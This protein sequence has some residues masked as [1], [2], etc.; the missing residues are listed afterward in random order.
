M[1]QKAEG[2]EEV[3]RIIIC[4]TGPLLHLNEAG[5]LGLLR[6]AGRVLIPP[7][8]A[9]EFRQ[10]AARP[11]LPTWVKVIT[12]DRSTK[13]QSYEWVENQIVDAGE[14]EAIGLALQIRPDWF[15][16]DDAQARQHAETLGL[17][18]HGSI[19]LILWAVV[20]GH[21]ESREKARQILDSLAHSSLWISKRVLKQ[22]AEAIEELLP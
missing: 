6:L 12:L 3:S 2:L 16:I 9:T 22:A 15:L 10:N 20:A 19:G 17:E 14:A 7:A 21:V 5:A 13:A 11:K 8:V 18:C 1:G 4:D